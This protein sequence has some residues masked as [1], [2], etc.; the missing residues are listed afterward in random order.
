[1]TVAAGTTG[2]M[3]AKTTA[4]AKTC[5]QTS[6][7]ILSL[8]SSLCMI[9]WPLPVNLPCFHFAFLT[10]R[11]RSRYPQDR[12]TRRETVSDVASVNVAVIQMSNAGPGPSI[13]TEP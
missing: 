9:R 6:Q 3:T 12:T 8:R 4:V 1:M 10:I 5:A 13:F 7:T 11:R 2:A